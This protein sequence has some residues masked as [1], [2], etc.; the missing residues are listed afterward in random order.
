MMDI[1]KQNNPNSS[2]FS[3]L[4]SELSPEPLKINLELPHQSNISSGIGLNN[5][6]NQ[7]IGNFNS[8]L[9]SGQNSIG[10]AFPNFESFINK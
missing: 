5:L 2:G 9:N 1:F 7:S 4:S 6:F 10:L 3:I 8:S